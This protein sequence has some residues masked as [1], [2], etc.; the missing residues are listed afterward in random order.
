ML[1]K[2]LD[3]IT[4]EDLKALLGIAHESKT[5]EFKSQLSG[6]DANLALL[7]GVSGFANTGGGDF[8]IGMEAKDGVAHAISG[9]ALS[10]I[11]TEKQRLENVL[12]AGLEPRLPR[13][14]IHPIPCSDGHFVLLIRVPYSWIGPHRVI[15]NNVFYGRNSASTYPLAVSELRSAFGFGEA[16]ADRVRDFRTGRLA[17]IGAGET[18]VPLEGRAVTVLHLVPLPTVA[19]RRSID[20]FAELRR[21]THFPLPMGHHGNIGHPQ[22]NLDGVFNT[23]SGQGAGVEGYV[24]LFRNGAVEGVCVMSLDDKGKPY[25]TDKR[26]G[27]MIVGS[28]RQYLGV[29][30][31]LNLGYPVLAM[32]SFCGA[33]GAM[34]RYS[35]DLGGGAYYQSKSLRD[36]VIAFPEAVIESVSVD[37]PALLR[38]T[39]NIVWNAFGLDCCNMYDG[40]GVWTGTA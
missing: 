12:Q 30:N 19:S 27:N 15:S 40:A 32:L 10:D 9:I 34:M 22:I 18:P 33:P 29:L 6:K 39:L 7:K 35:N 3:K 2:P 28:A 1:A 16:A 17:R 5:L 24:Q 36:E 26:F 13:I 20:S 38:P 11:D 4:L 37:M 23:H 21:G 25:V 8:L 31:N 14:D